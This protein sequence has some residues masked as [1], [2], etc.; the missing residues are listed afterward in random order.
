MRDKRREYFKCQECEL[1]F[2]P[3]KY[4]LSPEEEK[5]EYDLHSNNPNDSEYRKFL[6]RLFNPM[7]QYLTRGSCGLDFGSGPGPALSAMFEEAEYPMDIYDRFYAPD[8]TVFEKTYDFITST[9][10]LEHLHNPAYE[11][12]RLWDIL[13]PGGVLGVMTQLVLD[14]EKFARWRYKDDMTH[15]C[16]FSVA[17]FRWLTSK[18]NARLEF[19]DKNAI[20]LIK[21]NRSLYE[22]IS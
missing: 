11:L 2:V 19:A 6:S 12:K 16:F 3:E 1:I 20:F 10:T 14:K 13:K 5:A 21:A 8:N 4:F 9:E 18:W 17:T 15:I 7:Q 22:N